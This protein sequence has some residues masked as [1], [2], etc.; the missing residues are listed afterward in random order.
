MLLSIA[1][2]LTEGRAPEHPVYHADEG[3]VGWQLFH[4]RLRR[5]SAFLIQ[6]PAQRWLL[7]HEHAGE[8]SLWLLALLAAGKHIV[9]PPNFQPGTLDSMAATCD[10]R[11]DGID[12][13]L[14][15][16][17]P[18]LATDG[19]DRAC[20]DL[21]TSGSSG[22]PKCV[23]KRLLQLEREVEVLEGLWGATL[24]PVSI[25]ATVPHH[26]IYGLL[27]R[28]LWP[29]ASGRPFDVVQCAHPD[30]LQQRLQALGDNALVASPA[31]LS[32]LPGLIELD[33]LRPWPRLVFS[34]GGPLPLATAE[35]LHAHCD[36]A[37]LEIYGST[38]TG[39]IAWRMQV[40]DACWT[41][42]PGIEITA[43]A[44]GARLYSPFLADAS[45]H[46]LDDAI[47]LHPDGRFR[48]L[49]RIDRVVKIEEKRLSL[50]EM[51]N[52]LQSHPWVAQAVGVVLDGTRRSVGMALTL[53]DEGKAALSTRGRQDMRSLLREHLAPH[54]DA[55]LLP[56]YWRYLDTLPY[57]AQGK[58]PVTSLQALFA[59]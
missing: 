36:G 19:L 44:M 46:R 13:G 18:P 27:F 2:L 3:T 35:A 53:T 14:L 20:V 59:E 10:A 24:G 23:S 58:L 45:P 1:Q 25:V 38:E 29:L 47:E 51:E 48:L 32:R 40:D 26:H 11:A 15:P 5:L 8:F 31:Q 21:H 6:H 42:M 49:G 30:T 37:P 9:I 16:S 4:D 43:D 34:S 33:K 28:L 39:G 7:A 55:V 12:I 52:R 17:A 54:F 41:P 56:R 22:E 57:T 50:P